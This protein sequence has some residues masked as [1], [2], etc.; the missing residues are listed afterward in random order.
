[1]I[2]MSKMAD[3]AFIVLA[4]MAGE[5]KG[6]WAASDL[7]ERTTLPTP[8]VA[9]LMKLLAKGGVVT[10]QRGAQ[11]GYTLA[12]LPSEISIAKIVE[13][14]DG[15]IALTDCV[16]Q[17]EHICAVRSLCPMCGGWDKV[18][19]AMRSALETVFLSDLTAVKTL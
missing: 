2:R 4:Q 9:K 13:A 1:M 14:V 16:D 12:V 19:K 10:A 8:T 5:K 15:P 11:G 18:N 17:G 3:Y 7:A 6:A